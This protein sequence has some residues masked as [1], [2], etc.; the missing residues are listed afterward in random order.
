M[1]LHS[2]ETGKFKL[3]GG[4]MFGVVP[5]QLWSKLNP[6]DENNMCTWAMRCLLIEKN[7]RLIL[8]DTGMGNKQDDKF[9]SHFQPHDDL[10]LLDSIRLKGFEPGD[11]TDVLITHFHFDHVGG[12]VKKNKNGT[13]VPSFPNATYW[14]SSDHFNWALDPN[15]RERASFLKENFV[16]LQEQGVLKY[17]DVEQDIKWIEDI[18]LKFMFGH[19]E[20]MIVPV[21][22]LNNGKKI[23]YMADLLPST[24]HIRMP[25][26]MSYDIRPLQTLKE[27]ESFFESAID[28]DL[29][30]F[31]EHDPFHELCTIRKNIK[32]RFELDSTLKLDQVLG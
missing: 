32:G 9:R 24:G 10:D 8:I 25:Y 26:V 22:P 13:L 16:P 18:T 14:T 1:K 31:L 29:H 15:F 11:I 12:A 20:A 4:A 3:D 5:R 28:N 7:D 6:P 30:L 21:I 27:K 23:A 17:I 2:I 19:T